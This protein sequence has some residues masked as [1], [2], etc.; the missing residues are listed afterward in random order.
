MG[1]IYN[2]C[3]THMKAL[4]SFL[5]SFDWE[6]IDFANMSSTSVSHDSNDNDV[7]SLPLRTTAK[8][9]VHMQKK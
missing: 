6:P 8:L 5:Y 2:L 1:M 7:N 9:F 4:H 3:T